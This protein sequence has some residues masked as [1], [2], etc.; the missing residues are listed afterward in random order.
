MLII[1]WV[2]DWFVINFY[3]KLGDKFWFI[4]AFTYLYV[5]IIYIDIAIAGVVFVFVEY[6]FS[7]VI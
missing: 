1:D 6:M 2:G 3:Y 4:C 7:F 5:R